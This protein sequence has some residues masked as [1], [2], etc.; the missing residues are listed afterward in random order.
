MFAI[1][2]GLVLAA[3]LDRYTYLQRDTLVYTPLIWHEQNPALFSNDILI[4]ASHLRFH[5]FR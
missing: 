5:V 3:T 4:R 2:S 1:I